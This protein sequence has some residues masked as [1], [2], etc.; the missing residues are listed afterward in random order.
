MSDR[1][2]V[3]WIEVGL[4]CCVAIGLV[5]AGLWL[6]PQ[7]WTETEALRY[8][9]D[10]EN[11]WRWGGRAARE[12]YFGLYDRVVESQPALPGRTPNYGLDYV[13][14]RLAVM[15]IW[16]HSR[17]DEN[18]SPRPWQPDY[19]FNAP[20]LHLNT[21]MELA[22]AIG[23]FMLA[24]MWAR[25]SDVA[26]AIDRR[27]LRAEW[28]ALVGF[29]LVWFNP[30]SLISAHGRPTWDVWVTPFY[31]WAMYAACR[32]RWVLAGAILGIGAMFKGQQLIVAP[33]FILWPVFGLRFGAAA[34]WVVGFLGAIAVITC[35]WTVGQSVNAACLAIAI[36]SIPLIVWGA[37]RAR[38]LLGIRMPARA[39][40][41]SVPLAIAFAITSAATLIGGSFAWFDIA[42]VYGAE[43]FSG[44]EVGG[45]SSLAGILQH[46]YQW[47]ADT[48]V[49]MLKSIGID[50]TIS[51]LL[52]AIYAIVLLICCFAMRRYDVRQ[53]TR[54]LL[55]MAAPWI[56]YFAIFPKMHERYLLWG[57]LVACTAVACRFGPVLLAIFFSICST[58]MSLFQMLPSDRTDE[59]LTFIS[60]DAGRIVHNFVKPTF[61]GIG[62]AILLATAVWV[63]VVITGLFTRR[64]RRLYTSPLPREGD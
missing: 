4:L 19:A 38:P 30:A 61:P 29:A 53:D 58:I 16:A 12:G 28:L 14:L 45:A 24:R 33:V 31:V 39:L 49:D 1:R 17:L 7:V 44:L 32:D 6:R 22:A 55:A 60:P 18:Q 15:T 48:P 26:R 2:W 3:R 41:W 63:W 34:K 50:A 21:A 37:L 13:P 51:Q 5:V 27:W 35:P 11:A 56:V 8:R 23:V 64:D 20:L 10:M 47:R 59:F 40:T 54:F 62:W 43:K 42:F 36:A 57:A 25:R 9:P 52:I 46:V